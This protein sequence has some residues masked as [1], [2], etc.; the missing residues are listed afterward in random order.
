M[1]KKAADRMP[2]RVKHDLGSP[3]IT[4]PVIVRPDIARG[5]RRPANV[6]ST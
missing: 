6:N 5:T 4:D 3:P 1:T 2:V